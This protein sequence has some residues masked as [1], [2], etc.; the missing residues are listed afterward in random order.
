MK[1]G[2]KNIVALVLATF[3]LTQSIAIANANINIADTVNTNISINKEITSELILTYNLIKLHSINVNNFGNI[4]EFISWLDK[5]DIPLNTLYNND[6]NVALKLFI[7]Y[8]MADELKALRRGTLENAELDYLE[9]IYA[10]GEYKDYIH[11]ALK[12]NIMTPAG[13]E[14]AYFSGFYRSLWLTNI[15][16]HLPFTVYPAFIYDSTQEKTRNPLCDMIYALKLCGIYDTEYEINPSEKI[17]NLELIAIIYMLDTKKYDELPEIEDKDNTLY[18]GINTT[19]FN[20][21]V[22]WQ[23]RNDLIYCLDSIPT[24]WIVSIKNNGWRF[25]VV[26]DLEMKSSLTGEDVIGLC[27]AY[28]KLILIG[29]NKFP[30]N[31][32]IPEHEVAHY[33]AHESRLY[34]QMDTMGTLEGKAVERLVGS[35][36]QAGNNEFF[37]E[38]LRYLWMQRDNTAELKKFESAAPLTYHIIHDMIINYD[39]E[40]KLAD[41]SEIQGFIDQWNMENMQ[42]KS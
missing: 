21:A 41:S 9:S 31:Y 8:Y 36:S 30:T 15:G 38:C 3:L 20:E 24:K 26:E 39:D 13:Y 4:E 29:A 25:E 16:R 6:K 32:G 18:K 34:K 11:L 33:I 35:Y 17:S 5:H 1:N 22:T 40:A 14:G 19:I 12:R 23:A 28:E 2:I 27:N 10:T 7:D 37:A 42:T